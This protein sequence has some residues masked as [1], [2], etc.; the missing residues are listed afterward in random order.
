MLWDGWDCDSVA[1]V[2]ERKDWTRYL[3]MTNHGTEYEAKIE[4][5]NELIAKYEA[6]IEQT[7]EAIEL[8]CITN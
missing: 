1:W 2:M 7:R 5:L 6:V 8:L 3:K 4:E